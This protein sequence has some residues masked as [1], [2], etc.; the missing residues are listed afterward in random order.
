[1]TTQASG[2]PA[3]RR[4]RTHSS[5]GTLTTF[6]RG[7]SWDN[8]LTLWEGRWP[9]LSPVGGSPERAL[10]VGPMAARAPP[11]TDGDPPR[12]L[13]PDAS[14]MSTR[15][16][17]MPSTDRADPQI[18]GGLVKVLY[19]GGQARSGSTLVD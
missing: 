4:G 6:D 5:A 7:A 14:P 13:Y 15:R 18:A 16:A 17:A 11:K 12:F 19:L 8:R 9:R 2:S 3:V 1:M 10:D